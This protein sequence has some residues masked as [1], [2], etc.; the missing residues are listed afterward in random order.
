MRA[1]TD[2]PRR[3]QPPLVMRYAETRQRIVASVLVVTALV[4]CRQT[5]EPPERW[6][7]PSHVIAPEGTDSL[8]QFG[9]ALDVLGCTI[10]V[11]DWMDTVVRVL[12]DGMRKRGV[13]GEPG[14]GPGELL[15]PRAVAIG[16]DSVVSVLDGGRRRLLRYAFDGRLLADVPL[17]GGVASHGPIGPVRALADGRLLDYWLSTP[18]LG[19]YVPKYVFDTIPLVS[20][21]MPDG[22]PAGGGWGAPERTPE[23]DDLLLRFILQAGDIALVGDTLFVLR[24]GRGVIEVYSLSAPARVPVRTVQLR[25]YRP[26]VAPREVH[27]RVTE[28]GL[29]VGTGEVTFPQSTRAFAVDDQRRFYVATL[30]GVPGDER[31]GP[32]AE[33][34]IVYSSNGE[35][36]A[37]WRWRG[38]ATTAL[39]LARD[40]SL[41][42]LGYPDRRGDLG[43]HIEIFR[44][45]FQGPG[46]RCNWIGTN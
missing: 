29:V 40:G 34:L 21:L 31:D 14:R 35:Q 26:L 1:G 16:S 23:P 44:P 2:D 41:V 18:V 6:V 45:L 22:S 8:G 3:L 4:A 39:R 24:N 27:G 17:G 10:V 5:E 7:Q 19:Y 20:A 28:R 43:R 36:L 38:T 15:S 33:A 12:D 37:A 11:T 32:P 25:R 42:R 30:L 9:P 46:Q 13:L